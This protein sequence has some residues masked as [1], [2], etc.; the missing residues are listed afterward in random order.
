MTSLIE[1]ATTHADFQRPL[2]EPK[3]A[4]VPQGLIEYHEC[5]RALREQLERRVQAAGGQ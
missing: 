3:A 5:L 4:E 1:Q 2:N